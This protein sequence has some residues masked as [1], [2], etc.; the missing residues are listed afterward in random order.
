M[1]NLAEHVLNEVLK[2]V[3]V[4][5]DLLEY[6]HLLLLREE[7]DGFP[8]FYQR[9]DS[10]TYEYVDVYAHSIVR[11]LQQIAGHYSS[12][13]GLLVKVGDLL[14]FTKARIERLAH[15]PSAFRPT[16]EKFKGTTYYN[17]DGVFSLKPYSGLIQDI[18]S[19]KVGVR[20]PDGLRNEHT[21]IIG[22][23]GSGKTQ[24]I[25]QLISYDLETNASIIVIDS[26]GD[27]INKLKYTK[28]ID[29][30]RLVIIDPLDCVAHPLALNMF[31]VDYSDYSPVDYERQ[32]A[33]V[34]ETLSFVFASLA[35]AELTTKQ[36][37]VF[38][39]CISLLI[40]IPNADLQTFVDILKDGVQEYQVYIDTMSQPEQD[41]FS[42]A[43]NAVPGVKNIYK[44]TRFEVQWRLSAL[45]KN[46]SISRIFNSPQNKLNI[47]EAMDNNKVILISTDLDFLKKEACEF[48][49]RYFL[50]QISQAM[51][52]RL[53]TPEHMR[54]RTYLYVDEC[55]DYLRS[56]SLSVKDILQK[57]RK[58]N[59]GITLAHQ[60]L[61]DVKDVIHPIKTNTATKCASSL[62][63]S[64]EQYMKRDMRV[65]NITS[66]KLFFTFAIRG[67]MHPY[68]ARVRP[69]IIEAS[70][71]RTE[72]E[73]VEI[74]QMNRLKYCIDYEIP[75]YSPEIP[76]KDKII[77]E[78][79]G[80]PE[81]P[82]APYT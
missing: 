51:L 61:E 38:D 23:T 62:S 40:L 31:D 18:L 42:V 12:K 82:L 66:T 43:F 28:L 53:N 4:E 55:G 37:N 50:A 59:V 34:V 32:M 13:E 60:E 9:P 44:E 76:A 70:E 14:G 26:Q 81:D 79:S 30:D 1:N 45:L 20:F 15:I 27:L 54:K 21:H 24:L 6:I 69:G 7:R 22:S 74:M 67:Q 35:N 72:E 56:E 47:A 49:G 25:Q 80:I 19:Y 52:A 63:Y 78:K 41:F 75:N 65:E 8:A 10:L 68:T 58:Y 11:L 5:D 36:R 39:Y 48:F 2:Q 29:P 71:Q 77:E 46:P 64:D 3:P 73:M 57:G 17:C 33:G 16:L